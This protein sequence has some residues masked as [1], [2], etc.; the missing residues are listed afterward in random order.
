MPKKDITEQNTNKMLFKHLNEVKNS[1]SQQSA[2][3]SGDVSHKQDI[4]ELVT[5]YQGGDTAVT[6]K[7]L[8][9]LEP[10]INSA[11]HAYAQGNSEYKTK[12]K[13]IALDSLKTYDPT[14]GAQPSSHVYT[15]LQK[16]QRISADR[17][18]IIHKPEQSSLDRI[19]LD[20][21]KR[22]FEID[23][24]Y[25]PSLETLSDLVGMNTKKVG[26]LLNMKGA[27]SASA[28]T[29][30][31]G[32]A[33]GL[34]PRTAVG[35]YE[36]ALYMDL[37]ETNQKIYEWGT[38]YNNSPKLSNRDIAKRLKISPAAL[39]QRV[40]KINK[41]F[42]ENGVKLEKVIYGRNNNIQ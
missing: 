6:S 34:A 30:E 15:N 31:S 28:T 23:N 11:I 33:L 14:R 20:K 9:S 29:G 37:D 3:L 12:A 27:T 32:D 4:S 41:T 35:L 39:S 25:E 8:Q 42:S 1:S 40:A 36:D 17:G 26:R 16:L 13:I 7:L 22:D 24:G 10:T 21:A 19:K 2:N 18:N 5:A 38:G